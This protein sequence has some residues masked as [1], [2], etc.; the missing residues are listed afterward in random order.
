[1]LVSGTAGDGIEKVRITP[2]GGASVTVDVVG[3]DL[4]LPVG[5][6]VAPLP[7]GTTTVTTVGLTA[8]GSERGG[9]TTTFD[10]SGH[11]ADSS[12]SATGQSSTPITAAGKQTLAGPGVT[13]LEGDDA[14]GHWK[15]TAAR[16]SSNAACVGIGYTGAALRTPR[17]DQAA[18]RQNEPCLCQVAC[19]HRCL[20]AQGRPVARGIESS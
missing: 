16:S 18:R 6:W 19:S 15:V 10:E 13:M 1:V 17:A 9:G 7:A 11:S 5:F 2:T 4:G 14:G 8:D 3:R 20:R 12:F